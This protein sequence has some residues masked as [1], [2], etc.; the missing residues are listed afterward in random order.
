MN[1]EATRPFETLVSYHNTMQPHNPEDLDLKLPPRLLS[2]AVCKVYIM[3]LRFVT[4][5][6]I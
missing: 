5:G 4:V 3:N 2:Y 1:M 6:I